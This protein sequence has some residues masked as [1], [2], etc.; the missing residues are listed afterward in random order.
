MQFFNSNHFMI[1][2]ETSHEIE[3][4]TLEVPTPPR[5]ETRQPPITLQPKQLFPME[6]DQVGG[7]KRP[8]RS[9]ASPRKRKTQPDTRTRV[10][11]SAGKKVL[12]SDVR[13]HLEKYRGQKVRMRMMRSRR[14][15][16]IRMLR[17]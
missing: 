11:T 3:P 15:S 12:S 9:Q 17:W 4:R 6:N 5:D 14:I 7:S 16:R 1:I 10:M 8:T 13:L 2:Q